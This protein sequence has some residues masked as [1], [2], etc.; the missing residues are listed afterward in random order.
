MG[1]FPLQAALS[2]SPSGVGLRAV[3]MVQVLNER[4][5]VDFFEV[6]PENYIVDR[7]AFNQ[8][9]AL[10]RDYP[11]SFH[12]VGLSLG[13]AFGI[14]KT[15]LAALCR[16]ADQ[17]SP[18]LISDH[19]S[20]STADGVFLNDLLP[21]PYTNEALDCLARNIDEV[22]SALGRMLLIENPSA[23]MRFHADEFEEPEFLR[24]LS[25][26]TGCGI[27]LDVN[28][29]YVSAI[30]LGF[31][32]EDYMSVVPFH[33][34]KEIHIAGHTRRRIDGETVLIDDHGS[35][36][37]GPVWSL[38][39]DAIARAASA[40][41]LFEWDS[42]I[43][44]LDV[45]LAERDKAQTR[46]IGVRAQKPV[47]ALSAL[48][49]AMA[50]AL[51]SR[52]DEKLPAQFKGHFGVHRN[53]V[54]QSLLNALS[55]VYAGTL[56]L[57]GKEFFNQTALRFI[58]LNP[59]RVPSLAGYG[60]EFADHWEGLPATQQL[61]YLR[62]VARLEWAA[63]RAC[64]ETPRSG[65]APD[66]L[67]G[68]ATADTPRLA[69]T[70]QP[71]IAYVSSP[72]PIDTIWEF[73]RAGGAGTAPDLG[74]GPV[75]I[76]IGLS[77]KGLIMRRLDKAQFCFREAL[78]GGATLETAAEWALRSDPLFDLA[79]AI[80]AALC[81]NIFVDCAVQRSNREVI[82]LCPHER[83]LIG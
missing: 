27:L 51:L 78:Q 5:A 54:R 2:N 1:S 31:R 26:R 63:S 20:W 23:Y 25:A 58:A 75:F 24:M 77:E 43:P 10:R 64:L 62:D 67:R 53:N 68:L 38:Y 28:N 12:A 71:A 39:A 48:Q 22:Q 7:A 55:N 61:P 42:N 56:A 18:F 81:D 33:A 59:P 21:L 76:E 13:S 16:L 40:A 69:F 44:A 8:L 3:H 11:L 57:V 72:Y 34:V 46:A 74:E 52:H 82:A 14:D 66:R 45:L 50:Q 29:I 83:R 80:Q 73:A 15:H 30:N 19:L 47:P 32:A 49:S 17:L 70:F 35:V 9:A 79:A 60:A 41:T 65:L 36:V 6:H 37:S 4:P